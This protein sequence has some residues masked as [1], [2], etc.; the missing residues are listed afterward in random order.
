MLGAAM[1]ATIPPQSQSQLALPRDENDPHESVTLAPPAPSIDE[2]LQYATPA[3]SL[4]MPGDQHFRTATD[5]GSPAGSSLTELAQLVS[6]LSRALAGARQANEQ[7]VH[8]LFTLR[9]M[10]GAANQQQLALSERALQ[11]EQELRLSQ[12]SAERERQLLA[13]QQDDFLAAI[14]EEHDAE[15]TRAGEALATAQTQ[16][17]EAQARAE[18][19]ERE[20]DELRAEASRLRAQLGTHRSTPPPPPVTSSRLPTFRPASMLQLDAGE[21]DSTLHT[22]SP[23]PRMPSLGPPRAPLPSEPPPAPSFAPPPSGWTPLPPAPE[24]SPAPRPVVV[25][26]ASLPSDPPNRHPALKQKPDPTTRPLIDYSLGQDGVSSET[27]EGARLSSK[28]P[29]K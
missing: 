27:L 17:D 9:A 25:S 16:R 4:S 5:A 13:K 10:L 3:S 29:R 21:L 26:A 7:L 12:T 19:R 24:S 8:E 23:S 11:L 28:P 20:R 1:G 15:R 18:K 6:Q 14:L 2:L 22:R